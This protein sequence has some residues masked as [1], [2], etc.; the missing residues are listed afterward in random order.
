MNVSSLEDFPGSVNYGDSYHFH[1]PVDI[2][3]VEITGELL[4]GHNIKICA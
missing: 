1:R 4:I 3:D 2:N